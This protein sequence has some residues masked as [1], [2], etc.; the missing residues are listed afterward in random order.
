M[1]AFPAGATPTAVF[2]DA[3]GLVTQVVSGVTGATALT[4]V[5]DRLAGLA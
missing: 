4:P 2:V 5:F 1:A 3:H